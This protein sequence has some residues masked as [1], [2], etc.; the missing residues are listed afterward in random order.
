VIGHLVPDLLKGLLTTLELSVLG[1]VGA[2]VLGTVIAV[3]R[4]SP[5]PPLRWVGT[6]WVGVFR[7]LPVLVLL[8]LWVFALPEVGITVGLFTSAA[9][10]FSLTF[11]ATVCEI[12]RS[13]I[14]GV[15]VGQAEAARAIGLGFRQAMWLVI[16]PQA[17]RSMVQ[18]LG[19]VFI[20]VVLNTS[21]A[22][23][24]GVA[25]LTYQSQVLTIRYS[26]ALVTFLVAAVFYVIVALGVGWATGRV[27]RR[28]ALA[29]ATA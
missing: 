10:C 12:V 29:G 21:L 4:I 8:V 13:G 2:V 20:A 16:L 14:G 1:F 9:I 15:A 25:E 5:V 3:F 28:V 7:N 26:E 19:S 18:P 11:S 23:A 24:V 17:F 6:A 22:A 27:E